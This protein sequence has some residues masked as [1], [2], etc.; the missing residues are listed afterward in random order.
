VKFEARPVLP[1]HKVLEE[2][3]ELLLSELQ[4]PSELLDPVED[5]PELP[6]RQDQ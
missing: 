1:D 2:I 5:Y 3:Q 4:V 6:E